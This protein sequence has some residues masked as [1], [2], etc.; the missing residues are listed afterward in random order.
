[1]KT[2]LQINDIQEAEAKSGKT[3][4]KVATNEGQMSCFE[5]VEADKLANNVGRSLDV[6]VATSADGKFKNIRKVYED[7]PVIKPGVPQ[8]T[9]GSYKEAFYTPKVS[10]KFTEAINRKST[11]MYTSYAKDIFIAMLAKG[12]DA[13]MNT[14]INLVKQARDAF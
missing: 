11:T 8:E 12:D 4:Y 14:A 9:Q 5:K 1:M 10:N 3:Y 13:D 6:E 7:T 2:T